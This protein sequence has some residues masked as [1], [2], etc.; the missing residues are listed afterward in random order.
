MAAKE[1][2]GQGLGVWRINLRGSGE[3]CRGHRHT[4]KR[5]NDDYRLRGRRLR[6]LKKNDFLQKSYFISALGAR[7]GGGYPK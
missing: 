5:T 7:E 2:I 6:R 4:N 3:T 1:K